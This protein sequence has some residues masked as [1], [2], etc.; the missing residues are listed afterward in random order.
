MEKNSIQFTSSDERKLISFEATP[1]ILELNESLT[2]I[3]A[4]VIA[5][6]INIIEEIATVDENILRRIGSCW[7]F[8]IAGISSAAALRCRGRRFWGF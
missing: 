7:N 2:E 4:K 8:R 1:E 5:G 6:G 3:S